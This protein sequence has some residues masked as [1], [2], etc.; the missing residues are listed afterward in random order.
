[1][2]SKYAVPSQSQV[3]AGEDSDDAVDLTL[4]DNDIDK[5]CVQGAN[6][7]HN[8]MPMYKE[9]CKMANASGHKWFFVL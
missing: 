6:A 7:Y 3:E 1:V 9:I 4:D 8:F 5:T 2:S